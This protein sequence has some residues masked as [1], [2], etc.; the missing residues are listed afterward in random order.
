MNVHRMKKKTSSSS[1]MLLVKF[2]NGLRKKSTY[3]NAAASLSGKIMMKRHDLCLVNYSFISNR[4]HV[5]EFL[6]I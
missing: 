4:F 2:V 1:K 5:V 3:R 6:E